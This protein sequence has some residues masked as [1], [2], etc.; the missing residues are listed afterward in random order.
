MKDQT[1]P[2]IRIRILIAL[3]IFS[4]T[5]LAIVLANSFFTRPF[6]DDFC[7]ANSVNSHSF[8]EYIINEYM[9]WTGRLSYI[10]LTG[11]TAKMGLWGY[12]IM[13]L[14]I[15]LFFLISLFWAS[16]PYFK[17]YYP[18]SPILGAASFSSLFILLLF[19]SLPD[20]FE[21]VFWNA[22][23][24]NY[25]PPIIMFTLLA[26]LFIRL[27]VN[28]QKSQS[29]FIF[30]I[31]LITFIA[32]MFSEI[33]SML[34]VTIYFI[35][36]V[37]LYRITSKS[38]KKI[39]KLF[40]FT[41]LLIAIISFL[42]VYLAPGNAVR[43]A[44]S[45]QKTP[46][47]LLQMPFLSIRHILVIF[48][49]FIVL[50]AKVW[51][52]PMFL[53][54]FGLGALS[55]QNIKGKHQ[56][57]VTFK[58]LINQGWVRCILLIGILVLFL[59][60]IAILPT[61]YIQGTYPEPRAMIIPFYF[62]LLGIIIIMY[63]LGKNIIFVS[64]LFHIIFQNHKKRHFLLT[65]FLII[66]ILVFMVGTLQ[67][68][69]WLNSQRHS[70]QAWNQRHQTLID[71]SYEGVTSVTYPGLDQNP[72]YWANRCLATYYGFETISGSSS[73]TE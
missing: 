52:I 28:Y 36:I 10:I 67:N 13:P 47:A 68:L 2:N 24:V 25:L 32:G 18:E 31:I 70:A 42:I 43:Q 49:V 48:Y 37:G 14:I 4:I 65:F 44:A 72:K 17:C 34:Q 62:I 55:Q 46:T 33:Y 51:I 59:T 66:N 16:L 27:I 54:P 22:G 53:I 1:T 21:S 9:G 23:S 5:G 50:E 11:F 71:L 39:V 61:T 8:I 63:T 7:V 29:W 15:I 41:G 73:S 35:L 64:K 20:L 69:S 58:Q 40:A 3:L 12:Q 60:F 30:P 6:A 38:T 45:H 56:K 26:G 57:G 19:N